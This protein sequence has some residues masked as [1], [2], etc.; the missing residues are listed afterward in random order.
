MKIV[1]MTFTQL[2]MIIMID[3]D[4]ILT[5]KKWLVFIRLIDED[6]ENECMFIQ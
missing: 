5:T 3:K 2:F 6:N 4:V 1:F